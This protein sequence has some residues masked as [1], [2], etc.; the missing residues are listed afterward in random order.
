[1]GSASS[2]PFE[3]PSQ[4]APLH[5]GILIAL[6]LVLLAGAGLRVWYASGLLHIHRFE[7]EQYS[8][9]NVRK[10]YHTGDLE[11]ASGYYPSPVFN[12]PQVWLLRASQAV[13]RATGDPRFEA[14]GE[15]YRLRP[16][17]VL[18][19]RLY[20]S[21]CG[22]V[23]LLLVF[24]VARRMAPP[25]SPAARDGI[26]S[27][28]GGAGV[29]ERAGVIAAAMLAF[30]PWAIH[31]SGYNKP[32]ALLVMG[33]TLAFWASLRAVETGRVR[34]Y[35]LT[36][37]AIAIAMGAKL[38]GGLAAVPITVA[39]VFFWRDRRR[40][41][42]LA[43]AG[44]TSALAFALTNPFWRFY[45]MF[46]RGLQRDYAGRTDDSHLAI[47]IH[48]LRL[49]LDP[50]LFGPLLG[51]LALLGLVAMA[52]RASA[53][54]AGREDDGAWKAYRLRLGMFLAF[55]I[56]YT[57][58]YA[59]QTSYFKPNNFL[60][61]MPFSAVALGLLLVTA[62]D[63]GSA[64]WRREPTTGIRGA[65]PAALASVVLAALVAHGGWTY[66]YQS[67]VPS[68]YDLAVRWLGKQLKPKKSRLVYVDAWPRTEIAWEGRKPM[69]EG[70]SA[71]AE[72]PDSSRLPARYLELADGIVLRRGLE[73]REP[74][75][76]ASLVESPH[77]AEVMQAEPSP[78]RLRG[79]AL[80]IAYASWRGAGH[81][82][83]ETLRCGPDCLEIELP[84]VHAREDARPEDQRNAPAQSTTPERAGDWAHLFVYLHRDRWAGRS[85]PPVLE[86]LPAAEPGAPTLF[87]ASGKSG[88]H[89]FVS[90]RFRTENLPV[91]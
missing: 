30:T 4:P 39:T 23:T 31:S 54:P 60:P 35:V 78:F 65:W 37:L 19:T 51:S 57:A 10:I 83:V 66:V 62:W 80:T 84:A 52:F 86:G 44:A 12:L 9:Q 36:G 55:P 32:D 18:L 61:L 6:A 77:W 15:N 56:F 53:M 50:L 90:P 63:R 76:E 69:H 73:G 1:M 79:P 3:R 2:L 72:V 42:L 70:L 40:L 64:L 41:L 29:G 58:A 49:H 7:D 28:A 22:V 8:L 33:V 11:P 59:V 20:Q 13:F 75:I 89:L 25:T 34:D 48:A 81:A 38:T 47:P 88:G 21:L 71:F 74:S 87:W 45:L 27:T 43:V 68:T 14:V 91:L 16:T 82:D 26:R 67:R 5:R 17:G 85:G 46:I 24:L